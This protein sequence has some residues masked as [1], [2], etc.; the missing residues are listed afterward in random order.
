M[1][2]TGESTHRSR[3]VESA[4]E[5]LS[6]E[7][8]VVGAGLGGL[9]A[10]LT[11]A[12]AGARVLLVTTGNMDAAASYWAQGGI[13]AALGE[14]DSPELHAADTLS[15]GRDACRP[16][17]VGVL[18][19]EIPDRVEELARLGVD[20]D[21]NADGT[22]ALGR[23]GGHRLRRVAH[24]GGSATGREL[25][26]AL[27]RSVAAHPGIRVLEHTRATALARQGDRCVGLTAQRAGGPVAISARAT[28]L[29][30]GGAAALWKRTT[31]PLGAVGTGLLLAHS[32]GAELA[33]LEFVQFHPTALVTRNGGDGF[34]L[35]EALRGEGAL[36]LG[37]DGER[38]VDELA[39][40]DQV[41]LAI[42]DRLREQPGRQVMLDLRNIRLQSFPNIADALDREGFHPER[43]PIPVAP[44]AHYAMGGIV[45]DLDGRSTVPGLFA[46]GECACT[47]LHGANRLASNSLAECLVFGRRAALAAVEEPGVTS[48][49]ALLTVDAPPRL[50]Q[51]TRDRLWRFAGVEREASELEQLR[52]DPHPLARLVAA[53]ALAREETRG[54]HQRRD[55]PDGDDALDGHHVIVR[56]DEAPRIES[57]R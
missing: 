20:F 22:L 8:A 47:G 53:S 26:V 5:R 24:A 3:P 17:A 31:N 37:S 40:R 15:A 56:G 42:T 4:A 28:V 7:V 1:R 13:A 2:D 6:T 33:D 44:A 55:H 38:F 41:A 48:H 10:A 34:L 14:D 23:E 43:D 35:S 16:S 32:A 30:T 45:T 54:A 50:H 49:V 21:R 52:E 18:C 12:D 46:V 11:A 36:L 51:S 25:V 57:W 29:A 19:D 39:P 9:W 27:C